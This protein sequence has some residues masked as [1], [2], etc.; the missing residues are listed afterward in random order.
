MIPDRLQRRLAEAIKPRRQRTRRQLRLT[1][2]VVQAVRPD[3]T[4]DVNWEGSTT[5]MNLC[6][7]IK[8]GPAPVA[9]DTVAALTDG[10]DLLVLGTVYA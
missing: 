4:L 7:R 1:Y 2:G 3:N 10:I 5:T 8:P 9:G 6:P